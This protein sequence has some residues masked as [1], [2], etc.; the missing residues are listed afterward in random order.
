M[1]W[2][3]YQHN[4]TP[5]RQQRGDGQHT[6]GGQRS[7]PTTP[8]NQ[9]CLCCQCRAR[10]S[11][12]LRQPPPIRSSLGVRTHFPLDQDLSQCRLL[13]RSLS[14]V[15]IEL[16]EKQLNKTAKHCIMIVI[17]VFFLRGNIFFHCLS[18]ELALWLLGTFSVHNL[19]V[20]ERRV[21]F[22]PL[23]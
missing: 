20:K 22:I 23:F 8:G 9:S 21:V 5:S 1:Q 18:E 15:W 13:F 3:Q 2:V 10:H 12:S 4:A 14:Q 7:V 6:S 11:H 19:S 17:K 16:A